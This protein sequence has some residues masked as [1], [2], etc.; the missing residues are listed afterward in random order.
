L[1]KILAAAGRFGA[2]AEVYEKPDNLF[3][4]GLLGAP[5]MNFVEGELKLDAD[6]VSF[7][8]PGLELPLQGFPFLRCASA[9]TARGA[10]R[11]AR[12]CLPTTIPY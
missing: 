12:T 6:G 1:V 4:A 7:S 9:C 11:V 10:G 3:V 8:A 5:G 2:P